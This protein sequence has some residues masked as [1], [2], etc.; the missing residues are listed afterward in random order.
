MYWQE[1]EE[2][3]SQ[4]RVPENIVD[5]QFAIS[6]KQLPVDH[7]HALSSALRQALPWFAEEREAGLHLIHVA[8]SGNG[9]ERPQG[10][11]EMLYLS[12]RTRLTLRVPQHR[13]EDAMMLSGQI[14]DVAGNALEVG[15]GTVRL[16]S[17]STTLYSRYVAGREG[18]SEEEF[19]AELIAE[20]KGAGVRF[21][22]VLC[23]KENFFETPEGPLTTRSLLVA[24]MPIEDAVR[25]QEHGVGAHEHKKLGCG[26][27]IPHKPV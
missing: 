25:L 18:Q 21:K 8:E 5:I 20:L 15:K 24:E 7:A 1:E 2:D 14:L 27:F 22:K 16:L 17:V 4:F 10:G 3:G 13:V 9:W 6:C 11:E 19:L 26:L 12:R 23:G